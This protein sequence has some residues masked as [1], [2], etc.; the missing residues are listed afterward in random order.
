MDDIATPHN[1][2]RNSNLL[3]IQEINRKGRISPLPQAVQGAQPQLTGPTGEPGI[4]SEFGRMFSGIGTGVGNMSSPVPLGAQLPYVG[5]S[6]MRREDSDGAH[7][8]PP[9]SEPLTKAG[10]RGKR[11]KNKD[12]DGR[13][14]EE[15]TGRL[16][17][18]GGRIKKAKTH[19][20]HH[21]QYVFL[22][23]F[24]P[25]SLSIR[26][27]NILPAITTILI[28]TILNSPRRFLEVH[29]SRA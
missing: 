10:Q 16:T 20:H 25:H 22:L 27:T 12:D 3:N 23:G 21:H 6:L 5:A 2:Q 4:K 14:D 11:R 26:L 29:H 15:S 9:A 18:V 19:S 17:P 28:T 24:P 7:Q 1:N 8:E 13:G